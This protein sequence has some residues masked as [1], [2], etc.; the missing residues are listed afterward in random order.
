ME[1]SK[2]VF[3]LVGI[4]VRPL[5]DYLSISDPNE[6]LVADLHAGDGELVFVE[7]HVDVV[8]LSIVVFGPTRAELLFTDHRGCMARTSP[9]ETYKCWLGVVVATHTELS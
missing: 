4:R 9:E 8:I 1:R 7:I 3:E 6:H 5:D 2:V